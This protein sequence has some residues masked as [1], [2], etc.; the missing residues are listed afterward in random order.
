MK[1]S[2]S[3]VAVIAVA[4]VLVMLGA[5]AA[6]A[7]PPASPPSGQ[8]LY[9]IDCDNFG[10][11]LW[12]VAPSGA[13]TPIGTSYLA[14]SSDCAGGV[15]TSPVTG[16][17]Y[18]IYYPHVG[19][20]QLAT[21]NLTT[22]NVTTIA[23]LSGDTS[24]AWQLMITNSGAAFVTQNDFLF[25]IDLATGVTTNVGSM[26]P[27]TAGAVGYNPLTDT[28]YAI[29]SANAVAIYTIDRT[30]GASTNTGLG[31]NWPVATCLSGGTSPGRPDGISF[32]A[33]G[34]GWIQSDSCDSDIMS[35]D[36]TT[37]SASMV[38]E[39]FD[40]TGTLYPTAPHDFYSES[41]F[42]GPAPVVAVTPTPAGLAATGTDSTA[43][44]LA[45]GFA[46]VAAVL[47][48]ALIARRRR[49]A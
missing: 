31:G 37:G 9:A 42:F 16:I 39:L 17:T 33:A 40:S 18:F 7:A 6:N 3:S 23:A 44:S 34:F 8:S 1:K 12:S 26:A 19:A 48:M 5:P 28:I 30:T 10:P 32:D 22:G 45:G 13:S 29:D 15:Q 21:I 24:N 38:G 36:M 20:E 4:A 27:A 14:G 41:L 35:V 46:V 2:A 11:Q 49:T 47:G 43:I 25:S